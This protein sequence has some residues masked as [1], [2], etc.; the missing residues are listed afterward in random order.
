MNE[1]IVLIMQVVVL[2]GSSAIFLTSASMICL[3]VYHVFCTLLDELFKESEP[4]GTIIFSDDH[5][6]L[7]ISDSKEGD[8]VTY[9]KKKR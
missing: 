4:E 1:T 6:V 3:F 9:I 2:L 8:Y 5:E 7:W